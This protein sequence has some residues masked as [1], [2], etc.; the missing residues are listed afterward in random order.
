MAVAIGAMIGKVFALMWFGG[1]ILGFLVITPI[2]IK[3]GLFADLLAAD[4]FRQ[5]LGVGLLIGTGIA[6]FVKALMKIVKKNS[7]GSKISFS[8]TTVV[9]V[10]CVLAFA[11]IMMAVGTEMNILQALLAVIGVCLT[12]LLSGMITGMSGVNPMEVFGMLVLLLVQVIW[13]P[14]LLVLFLTAGLVTVACGL[15]GDVMNDLKSGHMLGTDPKQQILAEGI[16][17][18]IGAAIS[19]CV[20]FVMHRSFGGFGT[21]A[22][23]N[24]LMVKGTGMLAKAAHT[25]VSP[26]GEAFRISR[27]ERPD[28]DLFS[29]D[30]KHQSEFGTYLKSCVNYLMIFGGRFNGEAS[31]CCL[32]PDSCAYLR[33]VAE[34]VVTSSKR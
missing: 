21:E 34:R 33:S 32:D 28:I 20:L 25:S 27:E 23:F 9:P 30:K 4:L 24:R 19:V 22:E 7:K 16:G 31:N 3:T 13:N 6:V 1:A 18:V 26:I 5:N 12:C 29:K 10:V 17:G 8:K 15:S 14:S 11:V 2:G